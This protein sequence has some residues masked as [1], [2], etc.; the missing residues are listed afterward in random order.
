MTSKALANYL[1]I[2]KKEVRLLKKVTQ[3]RNRKCRKLNKIREKEH[4]IFK[5]EQDKKCHQ[6]S[7][8]AFYNCTDVF[9]EN[10]KYKT[11]FDNF[12]ECGNQKCSKEKQTL[13]KYR[14]K[15]F[16]KYMKTVTIKS[17]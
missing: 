12:I 4:K 16:E 6:K 11:L 2:D 8:K 17:V 9:Y 15:N 13:K 10:S 7:D 1:S 3:C 5:K 14:D